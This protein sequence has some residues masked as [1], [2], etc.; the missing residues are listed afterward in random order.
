[1]GE[2]LLA[3]A[4]PVHGHPRVC[5][6]ASHT[7]PGVLL[8]DEAH[9]HGT[10]RF[11]SP[12]F[13][14]TTG[15]VTEC[16]VLVDSG[17]NVTLMT[18]PYAKTRMSHARSS[19]VS[20]LGSS[21]LVSESGVATL[22]LPSVGTTTCLVEPYEFTGY[23]QPQIGSKGHHVDILLNCAAGFALG[24]ITE[25]PSA[26]SAPMSALPALTVRG[27]GVQ[28]QHATQRERRDHAKASVRRNPGRLFLDAFMLV[29]LVAVTT[30]WSWTAP[31]L[32]PK[33]PRRPR[34]WYEESPTADGHA[35]VGDDSAA[36]NEPTDDAHAPDVQG[37][38]SPLDGLHC[39]LAES[40]VAEVLRSK[41]FPKKGTVLHSKAELGWGDCGPDRD[42]TQEQ[43]QQY[44]ALIDEYDDIFLT[45]AFPKACKAP[46]I[47][48]PLIDE[49][50]KLPPPTPNLP[51]RGAGP[52]LVIRH[53]RRP[54]PPRGCV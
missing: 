4:T 50:A 13:N 18:P 11:R 9:R 22:Y 7:A 32:P 1:M 37:G 3:A 25:M 8:A 21:F 10:L 15:E 52:A 24:Y 47:V 42:H 20:A 14:T 46:P 28:E 6:T 5:M 33:G 48:I 34:G 27:A 40:K 54:R 38:I 31:L 23:V 12:A 43:R 29:T 30:G 26:P 41:S 2:S 53:P 49:D 51:G 36:P 45:E 17:S 16:C 35:P 39:F 44:E 19:S